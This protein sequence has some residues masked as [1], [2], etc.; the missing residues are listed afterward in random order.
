MAEARLEK[1]IATAAIELEN[2][3]VLVFREL[4]KSPCFAGVAGWKR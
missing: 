2:F 3:M 4:V 1:L